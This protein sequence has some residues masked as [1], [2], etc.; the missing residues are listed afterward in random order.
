MNLDD[1]LASVISSATGQVPVLRSLFTFPKTGI[2]AL[3]Y[4]TTYTPI[5]AI[6]GMNRYTKLL[7]AGQDLDKIKIALK[8]HDVD[9]D[10]TPN[11]MQIYNNL[12]RE[13]IGRQASA[14][15]FVSVGMAYGL[16][17]NIR[18]PGHHDPSRRQKERDNLGYIPYTIRI[19]G[20]DI[21]FDYRGLG[22]PVA[23]LLTVVGSSSYYLGQTDTAVFQ[24]VQDKLAWT[25]TAAYTNQSFVSQ[26]EPLAGLLTGDET[27]I[28]RFVSN[29]VRSF[30]PQSGALGVMANAISSS[31]KD[32]HNNL[33]EYVMNRVPGLNAMLPERIDY[34]TGDALNDIDNP[35]LRAVNAVNPLKASDGQEPWRQELLSIGYDGLS[36]VSKDTSGTL[37]YP[38]E[39]RELIYSRMG[40][41]K[42]F[43]EA[44]RL[45]GMSKYKIEIA[46]LKKAR[47]A[48]MTTEQIRSQDT[49][50]YRRLDSV[51]RGS[52]KTAEASVMNENEY[53]RQY[54]EKGKQSRKYVQQ[55]RTEEAS[56]L[57]REMKTL[58]QMIK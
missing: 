43:K 35:I 38:A 57:Q 27:A 24:D 11:A 4:A 30:I 50:I 23:S 28:N 7:H 26:L 55:G 16:A 22:E 19:P 5:M 40:Q 17:G 9:F 49:E 20:T 41:T 8:E 58:L 6:P 52:L 47:A 39:V 29:E 14:A 37:E 44:K 21:W 32:I 56:Q 10:T 34:W 25:V 12:R 42:P 1:G 13:Y 3:K 15:T 31:Q 51:V 48:G 18:G 53:A 46:N 45:L 2:N 54:I 33:I 36:L